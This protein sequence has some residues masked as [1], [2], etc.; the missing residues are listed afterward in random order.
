MFQ[1]TPSSVDWRGNKPTDPEWWASLQPGWQ[2]ERRENFSAMVAGQPVE[3]DL[4]DDGWTDI[5]RNVVS[6]P[7][8]ANRP[9][10]KE[11]RNRV[12]EL[13]DF[14]KMNQIRARVDDDGRATRRPPRR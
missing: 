13:A 14:Q 12:V 11:E 6:S 10:T 5:F 4:V 3:D 9:K 8:G 1:R 2:R 7:K